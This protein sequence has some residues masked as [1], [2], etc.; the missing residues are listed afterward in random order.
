MARHI[1]VTAAP[2]DPLVTNRL[3]RLLIAQAQLELG[4]DSSASKPRRRPAP[5]EAAS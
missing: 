1:R 3:V 2:I 4:R 5:M